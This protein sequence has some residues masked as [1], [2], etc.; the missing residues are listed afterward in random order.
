MRHPLWLAALAAA[1]GAVY[2]SSSSH[3][4]VTVQQSIHVGDAIKFQWTGGTPPYTLKVYLDDKVV[5]Q[6]QGWTTNYVQW[7]A[8]PD[9]VPAGTSVR[10]RVTDSSGQTVMS[11]PTVVEGDGKSA[12]T[13]KSPSD[14][15]PSGHDKTSAGDKARNGGS[16]K[17][18]MD[19][20][21]NRFSISDD[22]GT[23]TSQAGGGMLSAA[24]MPSDWQPGQGLSR[25]QELTMTPL[26]SASLS[27]F[28]ASATIGA[29][30]GDSASNS[31]A[32]TDAMASTAVTASASNAAPT[33]VSNIASST[34]PTDTASA[35]ASSD[36]GS[37]SSSSSSGKL[38]ATALIAIAV[39]IILLLAA[40]GG[41]WWWRSKQ[42]DSDDQQQQQKSG[43]AR[44]G[45]SKRRPRRSGNSSESGGDEEKLVGGRGGRGNP[46]DS[47]TEASE[48]EASKDGRRGGGR[49]SSYRDDAPSDSGSGTDD[50]RGQ[51]GSP[52]RS[53]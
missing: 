46:S 32:I 48:D 10:V 16:T 33:D 52:R 37:S 4:S 51:G 8:S 22:L 31:A 40:G 42:K 50:G 13:R 38:S 5:S 17:S 28:V 30:S 34:S 9:Q 41:F 14:A 36:T 39:V 15:N 43:A 21:N 53:R 47:E 12:S 45:R 18:F 11:E 3:I 19:D 24:V 49:A 29:S 26:A 23:P 35:A 1:A 25:P 20:P 44:K 6:N 2:A 27:A 7:R